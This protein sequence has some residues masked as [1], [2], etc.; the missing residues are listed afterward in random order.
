M[1]KID[2]ESAR[3][4]EVS[5]LASIDSPY[6]VRYMDSFIEEGKLYLITEYCEKGDLTS[7]IEGQ[8]GVPLSEGKIWK[9]AL[10]VLCGLAH[11]HAMNIIHRDIKC[12][13][14]FLTRDC[15]AKIGD[16]GVLAQT[17]LAR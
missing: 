9:V 2:L 3:I 13:N 1:K 14:I 16:F 5:I 4:R 12:R 8:M 17:H 15:N 10:Q 6:I 7:Y 11:L